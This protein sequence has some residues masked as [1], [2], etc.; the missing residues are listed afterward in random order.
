MS[1][2]EITRELELL[3]RSRYGMVVLKT[4][5]QDRAETLCKLL[6]SRMGLPLMSWNLGLGLQVELSSSRESLDLPTL[7][8]M[9]QQVDRGLYST[10]QLGP[11]LEHLLSSSQPTL[12]FFQDL[13]PFLADP[14]IG[15]KLLQVAK[16]FARTDSALI[17]A[18][19]ELGLPADLM[20]Q[21]AFLEVPEPR[22]E[23]YRDLVKTIYRDV[24]RKQPIA[25]E[26][27]PEDMEVLLHSLQGFSLIEAGK[28]LT[29]A[30]IEDGK[31]GSAD[32]RRVI[33]AKRQIL[34]REGVLEYYPA[35][36]TFQDVA[37][38]A[39]LKAWLSKRKQIFAQ[40]EKARAFGLSFPKGIL[41]L[42]VPGSGKS[43]AAKA[44]AFEWGL[45]LLK[46]DTGS[47]YNQYIGET[48]RNFR[49]AMQ[50]AEK[51]APVVL[52]IDEIEKAFAHGGEMDGGVSLRVLGSF[53]TWM[54]DRSGDVF[55]VA[56]ANNVGRLPPE[57]LRKGRFDEIFFVDLPDQAA[58]EEILRIHIARRGHD[59]GGLELFKLAVLS[60]GFSGAEIE[61]AVISTLYTAFAAGQL[62]S[63]EGLVQEILA[64]RSL[65]V[66]RAEEI[67]Q[68]RA[69]AKE[70]AVLAH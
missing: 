32:I 13:G 15:A 38:L 48:E 37:G 61:Q 66:T 52:W 20:P 17:L 70:R 60:E 21:V 58:R 26:M 2:S 25:F 1:L 43:L 53:L 59:V 24:S 50:A 5:D 3:V 18:S 54:Q 67:A 41:L 14:L 19:D 22:L 39:E 49:R 23:E 56:T 8:K 69:W 27:T 7:S 34:E 4:D 51:V 45:P 46:M 40:P 65:A 35:E 64:T 33:E 10:E 16:L 36:Y 29:K 63:T 30:M 44:V 47:L 57:L 62:L 55:V 42:G 31:L 28:V 11:A 9:S 6:A 12:Y 68:M